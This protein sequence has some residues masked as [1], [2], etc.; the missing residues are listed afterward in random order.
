MASL[1]KLWVCWCS[2]SGIMAS[3]PSVVTVISLLNVVLCAASGLCV[4]VTSSRGV[5]PS[6]SC[7]SVIAKHR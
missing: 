7:L 6:V 4:Q 3:N 1:S 5:I 2:L